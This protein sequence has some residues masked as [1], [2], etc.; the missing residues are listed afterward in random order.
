MV[1]KKILLGLTYYLPNISGVT[2]YAVIL[3]E[4]L[5]KRKYE[6]G[7]VCSGKSRKVNGIEIL[8]VL[9]FGVGKGF[10]MPTYF[11]KSFNIVKKF[12]VI[13]CH[14]PSVESFWL[15]VWGKMLRKKVVVTHHCEFNFTGT[16]SNKFISVVTYPIHLVVYLLADKI[17]S[18]T[19]DYAETSVFLR[20]FKNKIVYVLPPI[21]IQKVLSAKSKVLIKKKIVGFAGRIGWEK[22]IDVLIKAMEKVDGELWLAGPY[23]EVVGD[24]TYESLMKIINK[25][26]KFLGPIGH[27]E[28]GGFFE[29]IDCLVLPSTNNLETFGIVQ[30]EAM[31][32]GTPVVASNLPG[33]RMPVRITGMGAIAGIGDS[34]DLAIKIN[35]VLKNGKKYYQKNAKNLDKFDYKKTVDEYETIFNN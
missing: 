25:K 9:G 3:A 14:L 18:Y 20:F 5:L 32:C 24:K 10:V 35:E 8:G 4:E 29:K 19:Q 34:D 28:I 30:A 17:V 21:K 23:K 12:D 1:L 31:V 7:V 22:G 33:V 16:L 27:E 26:V 13:N 11:W 6:V 2:Q 15:A